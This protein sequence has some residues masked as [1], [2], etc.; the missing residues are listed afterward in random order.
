MANFISNHGIHSAAFV[1]HRAMREID[2]LHVDV[3]GKVLALAGGTWVIVVAAR[4]IHVLRLTP[5]E[6]SRTVIA[7]GGVRWWDRLSG[8]HHFGR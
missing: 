4:A 7:V 5:F 3:A 2:F 8:D 6:A 1:I